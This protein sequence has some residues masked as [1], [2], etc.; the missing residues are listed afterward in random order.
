MRLRW[1]GVATFLH[2][3]LF[4]LLLSPPAGALPQ[5]INEC[6]PTGPHKAAIVYLFPARHIS[7]LKTSLM[8]LFANFNDEHRYPVFLFHDEDCKAKAIS[9]LRSRNGLKPTQMCLLRFYR[10]IHQFPPGFCATDALKKG[11]VYQHRFPGYAHMIAFWWKRV[12]EHPSVR[13]L[14]YFLR[15]DTDSIIN[16]PVSFDWFEVMKKGGFTYGYRMTMMDTEWVVKGLWRYYR[17]YVTKALGS[18]PPAMASWFPDEKSLDTAAAPTYY[19]NFEILHVPFFTRRKDVRDFIDDF[20]LSGFI[21]TRRWGDAPLRFFLVH[22]FL[23]ASKDVRQ[24]CE[25]NY[26]HLPAICNNGCSCKS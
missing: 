14:E 15:L 24:F 9:K 4:F 11:V 6:A 18:M 5:I 21:Y 13:E 17:E 19:N 2:T 7:H 8:S 12:F 1:R 22:T 20:F 26:T 10:V 25:V 23:N 3:L 16:S